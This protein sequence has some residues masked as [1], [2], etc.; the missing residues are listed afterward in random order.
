M[1]MLDSSNIYGNQTQDGIPYL[2]R[3]G[4]FIT[5]YLFDSLASERPGCN[6]KSVI[7]KHM[8]QIWVYE[9]FCDVARRWM[10]QNTFIDKSTLVQV[11]ASSLTATSHYLNQ[12]WPSSMTPYGVIIGHAWWVKSK[13][14]SFPTIINV[15]EILKHDIPWSS[16]M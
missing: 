16:I 9:H 12:C 7:S 10:P 6:F 3:L 11:M 4:E 13:V 8:L 5:N 2:I 1:T 14:T 15:A